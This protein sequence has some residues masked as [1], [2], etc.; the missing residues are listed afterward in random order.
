MT[1][2]LDQSKRKRDGGS[3]ETSAMEIEAN[4]FE[5]HCKE[6][7]GSFKCKRGIAKENVFGDKNREEKQI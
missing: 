3:L 2:L 6:R 1:P 4:R 7:V 5:G